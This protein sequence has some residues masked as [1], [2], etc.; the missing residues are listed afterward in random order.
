MI[1]HI[2]HVCIVVTCMVE[3]EEQ[4][5][6]T[7]CKITD[8]WLCFTKKKVKTPLKRFYVNSSRCQDKLKAIRPVISVNITLH[9][10]VT[11]SNHVRLYHVNHGSS[12]G[13]YMAIN[14]A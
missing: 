1:L 4:D 7:F 13:G 14:I 9:D 3:L 11:D 10:H 2:L 8:I 12:L 5:L 6:I